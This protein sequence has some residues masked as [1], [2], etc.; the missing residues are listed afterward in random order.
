MTLIL[1]GVRVV[2]MPDLGAVSDS[3]SFVGESAGSGRFLAT[4]LRTYIGGT[5]TATGGV[6]ARSQANHFG[7]QLYVEDFGAVGDG[8]T[9]DTT[10]INAA[11]ASGRNI[12]FSKKTYNVSTALSSLASGQY[13]AGAGVN[14]TTIRST[15]TTANVFSIATG[16]YRAGI[17]GMTITRSVTPVGG[18]SGIATAHTGTLDV[19]SEVELCDLAL[20]HHWNGLLL[21][22]TDW[23]LVRDVECLQCFGDGILMVNTVGT[24]LLSS[25]PLQ[26]TLDHLLLE[27]CNGHG[28]S[29]AGVAMALGVNSPM[30]LGEWKNVSSFANTQ[31][32]ISVVG[33][34]N[35]CISDI[36]LGSNSFLGAD[37]GNEIYLDTFGVNHI[38][39]AYLELPGTS[40][41]GVGGATAASNVGRGVM[42]TQNN[43]G[44]IISKSIINGCSFEGVLTQ[45]NL[46]GANTA[47][48]I[49][50]NCIITNNGQ[51]GVVGSQSGVLLDSGIA[52]GLVISGG[53]IGQTNTAPGTGPQKYGVTIASDHAVIVGTPITGNAT[54]PI[55]LLATLAGGSY[56]DALA[57]GSGAVGEYITAT[58]GIS[59]ALTTA[60]AANVTSIALSAGDWDVHGTVSFL[61]A[62]TTTVAGILG[63]ISTVSA[64]PPGPTTG[65]QSQI[66]GSLTT[67]AQQSLAIGPERISISVPTTVY[68]VAQAGFSVSTMAAGGKISA[69]RVK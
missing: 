5:I 44:V 7:D 55:N 26:W 13:L 46:Y 34:A 16:T 63:G 25:S 20:D 10:A 48:T 2:D 12:R 59:V 29:V 49:V 67:G 37:G 4:A 19:V 51:A 31:G 62:G 60:V 9:D 28:L 30:P 66:Q 58:Q 8:V 68:L 69:R 56:I 39:D 45:A 11:I 41:T 3:A 53:F 50:S 27:F 54:A 18:A 57:G 40:P 47:P 1:G 24:S 36:R 23:G 64:T 33:N 38:I 52:G 14:A 61:P 42:I 65:L 32:G 6:T 43:S 15:S 22:P 17:R 21:G 35:C